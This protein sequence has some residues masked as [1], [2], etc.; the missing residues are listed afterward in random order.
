MEKPM[1]KDSNKSSSL[2]WDSSTNDEKI[3]SAL[4]RGLAGLETLETAQC[5]G[6]EEIAAV[7]EGI[8]SEEE[9]DR[10]LKH[11]SGCDACYDMFLL[12]AQLQ[13]KEEEENKEEKHK[14]IFLKPLALA[15]SLLIVAFSIYLFYRSGEIPKSPEDLMEK[16]DAVEKARVELRQPE[17]TISKKTISKDK[18]EAGYRKQPLKAKTAP[19]PAP[20]KEPEEEMKRPGKKMVRDTFTDKKGPDK[21]EAETFGFELEKQ[22]QKVLP[23]KEAREKIGELKATV[24]RE[25]KKG[26]ETAG[27]G[28][29]MRRKK[30]KTLDRE[31]KSQ[32]AYKRRMAQQMVE[33]D[34]APAAGLSYHTV[35]GFPLQNQAA[36]MNMQVQQIDSYVPQ[37]EL[38]NLFKETILLAQHMGQEFES[39]RKEAKK[40]N[41]PKKVDSYVKGLEPLLSV[42]IVD[43]KP[44]IFPNVDWFFSRSTPRSIEYKFFYLARS[45]WCD[46]SGFCYKF[47]E[48]GTD[49]TAVKSQ[50]VRWQ[51]LQPRLTGVFKEIAANTI[52]RLNQSQ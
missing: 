42:K 1:K 38:G 44:Y 28:R 46:I 41:D 11:V 18:K 50:L 20:V 13:K 4:S 10:V 15:A 23:E 43:D 48:K 32:P 30:S 36:V 6:P 35:K 22:E 26:G 49:K 5:P 39:L 31:M 34:E 25:R 29:H 12:T 19:K 40:T 52:T 7:V 16:S 33:A 17:V 27:E 9:R 14:I 37:S 8:V 47:K 3:G 24:P 51:T 2:E 45:G 21:K